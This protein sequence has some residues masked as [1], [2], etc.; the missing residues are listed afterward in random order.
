MLIHLPIIILTSLHPTLIADVVPKFDIARECQFEIGSKVEMNRCVTDETQAREK[1]QT[2]WKQFTPS[3]KSICN[4]QV[5]G[6]GRHGISSYLELQACLSHSIT[7]MAAPIASGWSG[8]RVGLA[9][10]GKRRLC[11][12][13]A[14]PNHHR[15]GVRTHHRAVGMSYAPTNRGFTTVGMGVGKT[16]FS[17]VDGLRTHI[18]VVDHLLLTQF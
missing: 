9:P 18:S 16:Q 15:S 6:D 3:E 11:K 7:Y 4:R 5:G 13:R 14:N 17:G 8:C 10:T 2:E 1:L 12:A